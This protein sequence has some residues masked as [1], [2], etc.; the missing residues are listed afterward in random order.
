[1][2]TRPV[3][4]PQFSGNIYVTTEMVEFEWFAGLAVS[5]KQKSIRSL[6]QQAKEQLGLNTILEISS[7]SEESL[8]T[9]LSAFNLAFTS[10]CPAITMTV[11]CAFQGSK[12]FAQ[13]GPYTDIFTK[14]SMEA[15]KDSRL[16]ESGV[17]KGFSFFNTH[18][19]TE[20]KTAFYDWL[21]MN[22]LA[23]NTVFV[24]QV[25]RYQAFT[26]IEFNP[27]KS[28]NCQAYSVAMFVALSQRGMLTQVLK[29]KDSY[30]E[31]VA[32]TNIHNARENQAQQPLLI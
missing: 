7:K 32:G 23:K 6:H 8:G 27:E 31:F 18:W 29:N 22:A 16:K 14:T 10:V 19:P 28:I 15:K 11:E 3:Y 5:Q 4:I 30:L 21:Y 26:D 20:P 9:E 24:E 13:G 2:A 17:L 12:V 25:L 1:M